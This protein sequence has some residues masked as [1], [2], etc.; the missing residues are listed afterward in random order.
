MRMLIETWRVKARLW[1]FRGEQGLSQGW[2]YRRRVKNQG[3]E[4]GRVSFVI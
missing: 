3:E 2:G 1:S 4:L